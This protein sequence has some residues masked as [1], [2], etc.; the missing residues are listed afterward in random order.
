L[1]TW[2]GSGGQ[3]P[4]Q[5]ELRGSQFDRRTANNDIARQR[6]DAQAGVVDGRFPRVAARAGGAAQDSLDPRHQLGRRKR[7]GH[8]VVGPQVKTGDAIRLSAARR[9]QMTGTSR[10]GFG[11][12]G[13]G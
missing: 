8:V 11:A 9:Q 13:A 6:I 7:L 5:I 10:A 12:S 4:Q 3:E 1:N 2:R